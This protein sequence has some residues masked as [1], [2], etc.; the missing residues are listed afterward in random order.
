MSVGIWTHPS[1]GLH[2]RSAAPALGAHVTSGEANGKPI[3]DLGIHFRHH[4]ELAEIVTLEDTSRS[5]ITTR[6]VVRGGV[7]SSGNA[8]A[9]AL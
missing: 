1:R 7:L 5:V 8:E 9:V 6:Y 3:S 4:I 2:R